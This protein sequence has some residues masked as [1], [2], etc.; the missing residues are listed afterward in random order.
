MFE[1]VFWRFSIAL[2][3]SMCPIRKGQWR[4]ECCEISPG[5]NNTNIQVLKGPDD[6]LSTSAFD[7]TSL[8]V[9]LTHKNLSYLLFW[10]TDQKQR[11]LGNAIRNLCQDEQCPLPS[12]MSL[13]AAL[14]KVLQCTTWEAQ[15]TLE[16]CLQKKS[17]VQSCE[18]SGWLF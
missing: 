13:C 1:E 11:D 12:L 10:I 14:F 5:F 4:R 18:T 9:T 8:C 16:T 15:H 17:R 6:Y 2:A 3:E 7:C